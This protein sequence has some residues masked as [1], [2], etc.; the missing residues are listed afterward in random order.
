NGRDRDT[1]ILL[2]ADHGDMLGERGMWYKMTFYEWAARVP[3]VLHAP[4]R[5]SAGRVGANVSLLDLYPT[6]LDL[7]DAG[8]GATPVPLPG[9]SLLPLIER[10]GEAGDWPDTVLGEYLAEGAIGPLVMIRRGPHK[11]VVGEGVPPQLFDLERDPDELENLAEAPDRHDLAAAFAAEVAER[12]DLD[13]LKE[14]VIVSQRRR[15]LVFE[16]QRQGRPTPWDYQ[17]VFDASRRYARN[18]A[19]ALG[20]MERDMR[21][22]YLPEPAPDGPEA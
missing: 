13:S 5:F 12:W 20:D 6:L 4:Q 22:P 7:A 11:Y 10:G 1:V 19:E 14:R 2:T 18:L 8:G 3:L 16:A 17:P 21:L 15:R 9:R